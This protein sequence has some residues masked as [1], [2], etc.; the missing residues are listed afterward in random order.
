MTSK[1][2]MTA[3]AALPPIPKELSDQFMNGPL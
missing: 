1:A 2:T 3:A